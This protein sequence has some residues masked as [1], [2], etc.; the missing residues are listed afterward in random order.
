MESD[1]KGW[2]SKQ[3]YCKRLPYVFKISLFLMKDLV[4]VW[5]GRF[6][7]FQRLCFGHGTHT[8]VARSKR[9]LLLFFIFY[10]F[11]FF[12]RVSGVMQ[13]LFMHCLWTIAANVDFFTVNSAPVHCSWTRKFYFSATFSLKIGPTVLFTHLK[14]I[15]LQY[16]QF[17]FSILAKI[18]SIQT[19]P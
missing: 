17:Q 3:I 14:N 19:Y 15:L 5:F 8:T 16:F 10:L 9:V 18:S 13:L 2:K 6:T 1:S 11:F 4:P 12:S 7:A